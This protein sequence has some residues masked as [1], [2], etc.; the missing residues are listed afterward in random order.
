ME[1]DFSQLA[2]LAKLDVPIEKQAGFIKDVENLLNPLENSLMVEAENMESA[3]NVHLGVQ[4]MMHLR[5]DEAQLSTS[6]NEL[7]QNAANTRDGC[8]FVPKPSG[9]KAAK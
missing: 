4:T 6:R 3:E 5:A 9:E 2:R 7:L 1:L 8:F